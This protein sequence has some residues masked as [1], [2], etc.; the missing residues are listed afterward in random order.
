VYSLLSHSCV[1]ISCKIITS[2]IGKTSAAQTV[3]ESLDV[4][5]YSI[6]TINMSAQVGTNTT[7]EFILIWED[8]NSYCMGNNLLL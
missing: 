5:K 3:L 8:N 6:L 4:T 7:T 1:K 2:A